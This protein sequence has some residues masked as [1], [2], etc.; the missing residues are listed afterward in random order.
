[1]KKCLIVVDY[2]IDFVSGSL[3]FPEAKAIEQPIAEKIALYRRRN[4]DIIFTVDTHYR[5]IMKT[6]RKKDMPVPQ[7]T[8]KGLLYGEV[9]RL[10]SDSDITF[11]KSSYGSDLLYEHL[12]KTPYSSIELAGVVTD[13]CVIANAVLAMT[14]QPKTEII[15][16][17][18]CVA[19][20]NKVRQMAAL[21]VMSGL[22]IT[23]IGN[24]E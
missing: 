12:K 7:C 17:T 19:S 21:E 16:D 24:V 5:D 18:A 3:G 13:I 1:M 23:V 22:H 2:Q 6:R 14:A 15:I 4:D 20:D 8:E 9:G 10:W 11:K